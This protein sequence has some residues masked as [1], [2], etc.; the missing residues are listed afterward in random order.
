MGMAGVKPSRF[1]PYKKFRFRVKIGPSYVAGFNSVTNLKRTNSPVEYRSGI[2]SRTVRKIPP[3]AHEAI[4]LEHG[5]TYDTAFAQ[6]AN[7]A[8]NPPSVPGKSTTSAAS[9]MNIILEIYNEAGKLTMAY[10]IFNCWVSE[11]QGLPDLNANAKAV[12]IE[13]IKIA[14]EGWERDSNVAE[15]G[16]PD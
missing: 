13:H 9:R 7:Q 6:W 12:A 2:G 11:Y 16:E 5:V 14:N 4:I 1:D 10:N 15:P 3:N 8:H